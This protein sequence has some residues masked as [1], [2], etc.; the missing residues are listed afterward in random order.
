VRWRDL[1]LAADPCNKKMI[2]KL[3]LVYMLQNLY[4]YILY[5][6]LLISTQRITTVTKGELK[7]DEC[8]ETN[9]GQAANKNGESGVESQF[10]CST[11]GREV[12]TRYQA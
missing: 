8:S 5:L 10:H 2:G 4:G 3:Y 7:E 1:N 12:H 9:L 6:V 11:Q